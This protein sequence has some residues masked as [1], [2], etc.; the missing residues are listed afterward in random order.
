[1]G[2]G[3]TTVARPLGAVEVD[4]AIEALAQKSIPELFDEGTFRSYEEQAVH[5]LLRSADPLILDLGGGAILSERTREL[6]RERAPV[7]WLD[8][9]VDT[10]WNRVKNSDRPLA[11]N[12]DP[13][14]KKHVEFKEAKIK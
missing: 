11:Q 5:D 13:V 3:K 9:D 12:Y 6:L 7:I 14:A 4:R 1:M 2:A 8:V 10:A